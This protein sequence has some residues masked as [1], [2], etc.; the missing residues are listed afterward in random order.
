[1]ILSGVRSVCYISLGRVVLVRTSFSED[2]WNV[3]QH[4]LGPKMAA[5][6]IALIFDKYS[7]GEV[8]SPGGYLR[9]MVEKGISGD[10]HLARSFYGRLNEQQAC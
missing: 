8:T 5:A 6:M 2:A 7:A 9:G 3:A 10:L 4:K 1:M